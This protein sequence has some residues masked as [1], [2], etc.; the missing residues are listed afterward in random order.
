MTILFLLWVGGWMAFGTLVLLGWFVCG[1]LNVIDRV[2]V[3]WTRQSLAKS[4]TERLEVQ[5]DI[6][7]SRPND[8]LLGLHGPFRADPLDH[9]TACRSRSGPSRTVLSAV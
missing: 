6:P 4:A 2:L 5:A 3:P 8:C 9:H 7:H 1:A